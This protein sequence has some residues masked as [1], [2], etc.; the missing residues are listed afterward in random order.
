P[1]ADCPGEK[2][3]VQAVRDYVLARIDWPCRL[4]AL[5]RDENLGCDRAITE[6]I[7]WFFQQEERGIILEDDCLPALSFFR[8]CRELLQKYKND[9]RIQHIAGYTFM[10]YGRAQPRYSYDFVGLPNCWGW[11]TWRRAWEQY[12]RD[13]SGLAEFI[14]SRKIDKIFQRTLPKLHFLHI[15]K[16]MRDPRKRITWDYRW[17]YT[18]MQNDG[19]CLTPT[20]NMI[21][22]I[23]FGR[24]ATH[25]VQKSRSINYKSY[26]TV[27]PLKHP[28]R[29]RLNRKL[30][31]ALDTDIKRP[32]LALRNALLNKIKRGIK[33]K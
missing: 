26:E 25:T 7:D 20:R 21:T 19:I 3:K 32:F 10:D 11:A 14:A 18:I 6:A 24:E 8:F 22:N 31:D 9:S 13:M 33:I 27:F 12:A 5:F 15:F 16:K 4:Q 29:I 23:G 17:A 1:R 28:L 2:E 30:A